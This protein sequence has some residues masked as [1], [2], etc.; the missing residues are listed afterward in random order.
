MSRQRA[1]SHNIGDPDL[2]RD[3]LDVCLSTP[4]RVQVLYTPLSSMR[5]SSLYITFEA[6]TQETGSGDTASQ[7]AHSRTTRDPPPPSPTTSPTTPTA[8][9]SA[10]DLEG[11]AG[12]VDARESGR[13][14]ADVSARSPH[15]ELRR[16]V[17]GIQ[18]AQAAVRP[19][20]LAA[21]KTW[22]T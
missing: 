19:R 15:T 8:P 22:S 11:D 18:I 16:L 10:D 4:A 20:W 2:P 7:P 21:S 12:S 5:P 17:A 3:R 13:A 6:A 9:Q 1:R 14:A